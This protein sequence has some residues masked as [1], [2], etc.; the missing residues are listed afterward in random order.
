[1][2]YVLRKENRFIQ[3]EAQIISNFRLWFLS[4]ALKKFKTK[5]EFERWFEFYRNLLQNQA[6]D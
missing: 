4:E 2:L 5:L 6:T 3:I 1:M